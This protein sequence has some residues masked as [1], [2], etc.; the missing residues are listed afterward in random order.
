MPTNAPS[1]AAR[2]AFFC[3]QRLRNR[4]REAAQAAAFQ[5]THGGSGKLAQVEC[6][7]LSGFASAEQQQ[8]LGFQPG[9]LVDQRGF[10]RLG[11]DFA[12]GDN[13]FGGFFDYVV[14]AVSKD[15]GFVFFAAIK[16]DDGK[17]IGFNICR[18]GKRKIRF[19]ILEVQPV[20]SARQVRRNWLHLPGQGT[21]SNTDPVWWAPPATVVP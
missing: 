20:S 2:T 14:G 19:H 13:V 9:W 11:S 1:T 3:F 16:H 8:A 15:V 10:K 5:R 6:R 21:I 4:E 12:A 17:A 7:E 18:V